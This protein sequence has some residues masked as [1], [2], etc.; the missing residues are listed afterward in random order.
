MSTPAPADR[1]QAAAVE[2]E[3]DSQHPEAIWE[4]LITFDEIE[5]E[6]ARS[7]AEPGPDFRQSVWLRPLVAAA[8]GIAAL[9]L[10]VGLIV[11][12]RWAGQRKFADD[13]ASLAES[14]DQANEP[15]TRVVARDRAKAGTSSRE[16][17]SPPP[18]NEDSTSSSLSPSEDLA[19]PP[20][21]PSVASAPSSAVESPPR[22]R[23]TEPSPS[24]ARL[25]PPPLKSRRWDWIHD[26][27]MPALD[28][29]VENIRSRGFRPTFVNGHDLAT[30]VRTARPG[31]RGHGSNGSHRRQG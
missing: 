9:V 4:K 12:G 17:A 20:A 3:R 15:A 23:E 21:M 16:P 5:Q 31:G 22:K 29:W 27:P 11:Y 18:A 30:Q 24:A 28:R 25:L 10:V 1:A 13:D 2:H 8:S 14:A 26:A 19:S 6:K 7:L